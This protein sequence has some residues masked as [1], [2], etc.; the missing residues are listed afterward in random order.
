MFSGTRMETLA[1][2][3]VLAWNGNVC[4]VLSSWISPFWL[5]GRWLAFTTTVSP[6]LTVVA[7]SESAGRAN[8]TR[9]TP[10]MRSTT[11]TPAAIAANSPLRDFFLATA[12]AGAGYGT[13]TVALGFTASTRAGT[14][15]AAAATAA[16]A[17]SG[18]VEATAGVITNVRA[19]PGSVFPASPAARA[20]TNAVQPSPRAAG[21]LAR[22]RMTTAS[23]CGLSELLRA[24]GSGG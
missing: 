23:T 19:T 5:A 16:G 21:S 11:R 7:D 10:R 13:A 24:L 14:G 4:T 6:A 3:L 18:T 12:W 8:A 22:P 9:S 1:S 17:A 15:I 20:A 2:P